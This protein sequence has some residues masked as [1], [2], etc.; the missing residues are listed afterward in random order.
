MLETVKKKIAQLNN[1]SQTFDS[2]LMKYVM[3]IEDD[4]VEYEV[5]GL[6]KRHV[7]QANDVAKMLNEE[8]DQLSGMVEDI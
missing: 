5:S 7:L 1:S 3:K 6:E 4:N 2:Y 8:C